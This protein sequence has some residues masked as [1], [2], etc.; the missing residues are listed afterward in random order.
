MFGEQ[1]EAGPT[2][3]LQ[4]QQDAITYL[5]SVLRDPLG[6]RVLIG[7]PS[8]GKTTISQQFLSVL[9]SDTVVA[10]VNGSG[11]DAETFLASVLSQ[12][13]Y[14]IDLE[15][16]D[17]LLRIVSVF[18]VQQTRTFQPPMV[19]VENVEEMKP[20]ALRSVCLLASLKFQDKY[21]VRIVL[22]GNGQVERLLQSKGMSAMS[23]RLESVYEVERLSSSESMLLLHGRLTSCEGK[24]PDA[25]LPTDVCDRIHELSGGN[26]G[27]LYEIAGGTLEQALSLPAT[28]SDVNKYQHAAR[29]E[30]SK[31]KLIVSLDGEVIETCELQE[32][33]LTIGRSNLADM[34]V[35]N[36]YASKFHALLLLHADALVLVDLNSANGTFVNSVRVDSTILR[37]N[38]IIS[39]ATYRIKVVDAP[40][41]EFDQNG[42]GG[43][44]DTTRMKTL[45]DMRTQR[46]QKFPFIDIKRKERR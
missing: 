32:K 3:P 27:R 39:L 26:P 13:G 18:A 40:D 6:A 16:A 8:S 36:E 24:Q 33:K 30:R 15:S 10:L 12:F 31:T 44:S 29:T 2:V 1:A 35:H 34:V 14:P 5:C 23:N 4:T 37:S 22:T 25:V 9:R 19:I 46:K 17:D 28:V 21:A 42:D 38:D 45:A 11:L 20:A 41:A 7:P 43:T